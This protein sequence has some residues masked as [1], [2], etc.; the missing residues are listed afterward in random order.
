VQALWH[1]RAWLWPVAV[2][3]GLGWRLAAMG[4][5][6]WRAN[7]LCALGALGFA[8]TLGQGFVV[9]QPGMGLGAALCLAAFAALL[10]F[11]IAARGAFKGDAFVAG[12]VVGIALLVGLFTFFPVVKILLSAFEDA[13]GAPSISVLGQRLFAEKIWGLGC[14]GGGTRCGVA[15]NTLFLAL[16]CATLCTAL[17]L[18]FALIV[19]RTAFPFKRALRIVSLLPIITPPF[20]IGLGLILLFGRSG[21][22]NQLLEWA[23]G[24]VPTRWIYGYP[25]VLLAQ[26]FAFTPIAF[27]VLIGVVEGV[28]PSMEE[29]AQT[30]RAGR[31]TTFAT[32]SLPLMRPGLAN[33]FLISFIESIADFGNPIVLGGNFGVLSTEVFFSVVGAQLDQGRAAT[34]GL[35]LLAFALAAFLGQ[36]YALGHRSY[37]SMTGK[38]DAGLPSPLPDAVRRLCYAVVVPW[39]VLTLVIYAMALAGGFVETWGRNYTPTLKHYVKA[40][41]LDWGPAGLIWAGAA[42]NSFWT[43]VNLSAIAAPL[44]AGL[45]ILAA[46][47]LTRHDF[48]GRSAFEFG[49]M[50]SFAI[51][52]TVIGVSYI[53]AF[54]VPPIEIT[55]TAVILVVCNVFRNM[56]VGVRAGM[57][58]MAQVDRSLDEASTTLGARGAT[59]LRTSLLPLLKPAVV[60]ALVYSFVRAVTTVSAVIFLVS[61]EYE[62]AT[63]YIINRVVNGDYG[64]A[65]AY[66]SVLIVLMLAVIG[67]IQLAVGTRRLGRRGS[68]APMAEL[69]GSAA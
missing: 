35:L 1:G 38:G 47:L 57:A 24:I 17:G 56:P 22:V 49:T 20:V 41:G 25:G 6:R 48:A 36:R 60:A 3:L 43:T 33:A 29:A 55:G 30:L 16:S 65:I 40:F 23:F 9:A 5:T 42:W 67:L 61:A 31:W 19:T 51:P 12:C 18:A 54:N 27:L 8:Y 14:L 69:A 15:W 53:L 46:W 44:T 11:G 50:L 39:V 21:L 59:T 58:A 68:A 45:G 66:C 26:V 32:V 2:F 62:W 13:G 10:A 28:A 64:V 63:T 52:G 34:L 7:G 4:R 37:A